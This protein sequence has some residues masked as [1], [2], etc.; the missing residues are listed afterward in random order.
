MAFTE[1]DLRAVMR[2]RS[3]TVPATPELASRVQQRVRRRRRNELVA[4]AVALVLVLSGVALVAIPRPSTTPPVAPSPSTGPTVVT[5]QS[6]GNLDVITVGPPA[7]NG[8]TPIVLKMTVRNLGTRPW[9]GIVAIGVVDNAV[10]PGWFD[11]GLFT[12]SGS[13]NPVSGFGGAMPDSSTADGNSVTRA[14]DG[15]SLDH[16]VVLAAG[17]SGSWTFT[18]QRD[19]TTEVPAAVVGWVPFLSGQGQKTPEFGDVARAT[20]ITVTRQCATR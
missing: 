15:V 10:I 14:F 17:E 13:G 2:E 11:G 16:D 19:L 3:A 20:A 8:T 6:L 4:V 12:G 7:I 1:D 9:R 5:E 18:V